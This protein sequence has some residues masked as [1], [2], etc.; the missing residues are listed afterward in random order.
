[1]A[2]QP[3]SHTSGPIPQV[4]PPE[5]ITPGEPP[6]PVPPMAGQQVVVGVFVDRENAA[7][8]IRDLRQE[9][10]RHDQIGVAVR[11]RETISDAETVEEAAA[12]GATTGAIFGGVVGAVLGALVVGVIPG[13]GPVAAA[14]ILTGVLGGAATGVVAGGLLGSLIG[15]GIPEDEARFYYEEL[16]AGRVLVTVK[17]EGRTA[18]ASATLARHGA[19]DVRRA[20]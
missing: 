7:A 19:Y 13:I 1:M 8:A 17:A 18:E 4:N 3:I 9:G 14:G 20:S 16:L 5:P 12:D 10:F 11:G 6:M 15:M 2:M